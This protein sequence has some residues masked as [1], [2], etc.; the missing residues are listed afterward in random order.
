M[1][2]H[3]EHCYR[4]NATVRDYH[5]S[6][7]RART[8]EASG[9]HLSALS[10][11]FRH[12]VCAAKRQKLLANEPIHNAFKAFAASA[13]NY[14]AWVGAYIFMP[15]HFHLFVAID[16][17]KLSL[18][19]CVKSLKGT[20]S[21]VLRRERKSPPYWQKGFFDH[22]LRSKESYSQKWNYVRE[23]PVRAELVKRWEDWPYLGEIFALEFHD[24][25]L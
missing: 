17:E 3:I 5:Y 11:I 20:L 19:A 15:D 24:A 7:A 22:M 25:R 13:P 14:G 12:C 21:S 8:P 1:E 2:A 6:S 18:S 10:H 23:N 16:D 4:K 9:H